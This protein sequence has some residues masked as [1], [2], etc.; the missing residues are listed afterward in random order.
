METSV[1]IVTH[2][3]KP[4]IVSSLDSIFN[5]NSYDYEVIVVDNASSDGTLKHLLSIHEQEIKSGKLKLISLDQNYGPAFARNKGAKI[6]KGEYLSFLDNDTQVKNDWITEAIK[7][8]QRD[9]KIGCIQCK[10][11][12]LKEKNKYDYA[13]DYL[14]QYGFLVQRT[15]YK[16]TDNG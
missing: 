16:E 8:F 2:N 3:G 5:S 14:N 6:A 10:L 1:I 15:K 9:K 11:L 13:G 7:I 12:L 4:Y